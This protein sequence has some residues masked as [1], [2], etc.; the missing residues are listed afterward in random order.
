[1][2][3][4][5]ITEMTK[6][7]KDFITEMTKESKEFSTETRR[8]I[9]E[10]EEV[11]RLSARAT[12]SQS[13]HSPSGQSS[14]A[15]VEY[16]GKTLESATDWADAVRTALV[17]ESKGYPDRLEGYLTSTRAMAELASTYS[18]RLASFFYQ[19]LVHAAATLTLVCNE[20]T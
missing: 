17:K 1:M 12:A 2:V 14:P 10:V 7:S 20:Y 19:E 11:Y 8:R 5:F 15:S 3:K 16:H 13:S 6:E 4:D 9:T 18:L